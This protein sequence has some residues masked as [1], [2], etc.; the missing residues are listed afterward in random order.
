MAFY[1]PPVL[2]QQLYVSPNSEGGSGSKAPAKPLNLKSILQGGES[3]GGSNYS[4]A[5]QNRNV[6]RTLPLNRQRPRLEEGSYEAQ[7]ASLSAA[8]RVKQDDLALQ[9]SLERMDKLEVLR[10][11]L[12]ESRGYGDYYNESIL[13]NKPEPEKA[14]DKSGSVRVYRGQEQTYDG[15]KRVFSVD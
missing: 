2:A 1:A 12:Y 9:I 7:M 10:K 6:T 15:P 13:G 3:A 5:I 14:E 8:D 11:A 4:S